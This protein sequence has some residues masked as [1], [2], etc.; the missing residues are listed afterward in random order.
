MSQGINP[1]RNKTLY[2]TTNPALPMSNWVAI[3][4]T[5]LQGNNIVLRDT[6]ATNAH[7]F[8]ILKVSP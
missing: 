4:T 3:L 2:A 5:N 6:N 1:S 8:Y 7:L